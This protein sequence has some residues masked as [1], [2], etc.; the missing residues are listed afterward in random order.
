MLLFPEQHAPK[1]GIGVSPKSFIKA[2]A[3]I[4]QAYHQSLPA[5]GWGGSQREHVV[6]DDI[7]LG[8]GQGN[9]LF[10]IY[11]G[12]L[13]MIKA[14]QP[15][16]FVWLMPIIEEVIMKQCAAHKAPMVA[17]QMQKLHQFQAEI[18]Y[19]QTVQQN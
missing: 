6:G 5:A 1:A 8:R 18:G 13:W 15:M 14:V 2:A 17:F 19:S 9:I 16:A 10:G 4:H 11:Q 12:T 3:L 7:R